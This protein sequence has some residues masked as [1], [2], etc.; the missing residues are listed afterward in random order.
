MQ[1]QKTRFH[2]NV[3][4][5]IRLTSVNSISFSAHFL[6]AHL[7]MLGEGVKEDLLGE[8]EYEGRKENLA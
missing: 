3:F 5:C 4:N 8:E 1:V 6:L 2:F 7:V